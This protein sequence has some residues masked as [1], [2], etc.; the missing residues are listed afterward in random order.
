MGDDRLTTYE[1]ALLDIL[2]ETVGVHDPWHSI[3]LIHTH[4]LIRLGQLGVG[5]VR[6]ITCRHVQERT[7]GSDIQQGNQKA[8]SSAHGH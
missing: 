4:C 6:E 1:N 7:H 5:T 3:R 2:A 8:S